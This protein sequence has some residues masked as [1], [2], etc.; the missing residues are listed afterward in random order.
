MIA[1]LSTGF[2]SKIEGVCDLHI[3]W[4]GGSLDHSHLAKVILLNRQG[5]FL[6]EDIVVHLGEIWKYLVLRELA[7]SAEKVQIEIP[8]VELVLGDD[9]ALIHL[10]DVEAAYLLTIFN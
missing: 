1:D 4:E 7:I 5:L 3:R 6:E 9:W 8:F 10:L 2:F